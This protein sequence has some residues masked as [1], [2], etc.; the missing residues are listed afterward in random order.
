MQIDHA[1]TFR[2]PNFNEILYKMWMLDE[3]DKTTKESC[4][5]GNYFFYVK[6]WKMVNLIK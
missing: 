5:L 4:Y 2:Q 6:W 3:Q 1:A